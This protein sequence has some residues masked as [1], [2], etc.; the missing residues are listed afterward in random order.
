MSSSKLNCFID[1][2][3]KRPLM[4]VVFKTKLFYGFYGRAGL[5]V[6][7][8]LTLNYFIDSTRERAMDVMSSSKRILYNAIGITSFSPFN[9][10]ELFLNLLNTYWPL[11]ILSFVLLEHCLILKISLLVS[12]A[13]RHIF[14]EKMMVFFTTAFYEFRCEY[15]TNTATL[16]P[17]SIF[18]HFSCFFL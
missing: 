11:N 18:I 2:T 17:F 6:V 15:E 14:L 3:R 4:Y 5:D 1:S 7:M 12:E 16:S 8:P 10:I 13:E 9:L